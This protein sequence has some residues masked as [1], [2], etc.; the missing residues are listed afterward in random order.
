MYS[1]YSVLWSTEV[2]VDESIKDRWKQLINNYLDPMSSNLV[3]QGKG[4]S[5][6]TWFTGYHV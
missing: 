2:Q 6:G 3:P 1:D 4:R 5:Y